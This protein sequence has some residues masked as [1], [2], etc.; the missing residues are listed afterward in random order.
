MGSNKHKNM[1]DEP[2]IP[3]MSTTM[4]STATDNN[5]I[6]PEHL[7][8]GSDVALKKMSFLDLPVET[9]KDIFKNVGV[10]TRL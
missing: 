6:G 7:L 5:T 10:P 9:Q 4:P 8:G 2:S 1:A 3:P